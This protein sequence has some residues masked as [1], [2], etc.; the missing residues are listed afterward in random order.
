MTT[1]KVEDGERRKKPL[2]SV[3]ATW[4]PGRER[5]EGCGTRKSQRSEKKRTKSG[6]WKVGVLVAR[7]YNGNMPVFKVGQVS[8]NDRHIQHFLL[9]TAIFSAHGRKIQHYYQISV[10]CSRTTVPSFKVILTSSLLLFYLDSHL[11]LFPIIYCYVSRFKGPPHVTSML[12][13]SM[14]GLRIAGVDRTEV[15]TRNDLG[16]C[17]NP[18]V[19]V[20]AQLKGITSSI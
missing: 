8:A 2:S 7:K 5:H 1:T 18:F 19:L 4:P 9:R 15:G 20:D 10:P 6:K 11:Y 14:A 16:R 17:T 12:A 3:H 13:P